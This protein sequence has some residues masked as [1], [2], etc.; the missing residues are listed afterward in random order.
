LGVSPGVASVVAG[1]A[2]LNF[3]PSLVSVPVDSKLADLTKQLPVG[4]PG[5]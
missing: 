3:C 4:L 1:I 5:F 2:V